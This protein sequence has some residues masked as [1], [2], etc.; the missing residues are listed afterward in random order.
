MDELP[1]LEKLSVAEKDQLIRELRRC[2]RWF[3]IWRRK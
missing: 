3:A 2:V 1:D